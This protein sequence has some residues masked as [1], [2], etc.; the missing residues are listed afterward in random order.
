MISMPLFKTAINHA[1]SAI[2]T[3]EAHKHLGIETI[4]F[5]S[6]KTHDAGKLLPL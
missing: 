3:K 1:G 6:S 2:R 4:C 5:T